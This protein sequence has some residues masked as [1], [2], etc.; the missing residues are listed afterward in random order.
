MVNSCR[1]RKAC[2]AA[3]VPCVGAGQIQSAQAG[4]LQVRD[5]AIA[6]VG[7]HPLQTCQLVQPPDAFQAL[8]IDLARYNS[9]PI[10]P[11]RNCMSS[12][13]SRLAGGLRSR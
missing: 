4:I 11:I 12:Q 9:I 3:C 7:I 6:D 8:V 5:A 13:T 2:T 10:S 1:L